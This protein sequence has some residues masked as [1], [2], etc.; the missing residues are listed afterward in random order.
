MK[1]TGNRR[2]FGKRKRTLGNLLL[3]V[4]EINIAIGFILRRNR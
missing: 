3:K 2:T 4:A 1:Q